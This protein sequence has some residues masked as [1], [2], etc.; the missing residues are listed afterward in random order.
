VLF[1][2]WSYYNI[3]VL[4]VAMLAAVEL[5]RRQHE[6]FVTDEWASVGAGVA[7]LDRQLS[8][9]SLAGATLRG[10]APAALGSPVLIAVEGVGAVPARV[11]RVAKNEFE[12]LF[13][14][15]PSQHDALLLKLFSGRYGAG[16]EETK[17]SDVLAAV[18][19]RVV[20]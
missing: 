5:P 4:A 9:L 12:V 6:R 13:D 3:A 11:G 1:L 7:S 15:S 2:F 10:A 18:A 17:F 8:E 16:P 20:Q 14:L 19:L